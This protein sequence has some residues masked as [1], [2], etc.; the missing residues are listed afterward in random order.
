MSKTALLTHEAKFLRRIIVWCGASLSGFPP[1]V[2]I[3]LL[4]QN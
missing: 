3:L 2:G 1:N 4:W